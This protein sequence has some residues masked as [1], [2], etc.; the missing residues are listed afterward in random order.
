MTRTRSL[1]VTLLTVPLL[2]LATASPALAV[3]LE[4]KVAVLTS[5]TQTS[6]ASQN[7]FLSARSNQS[8]WA[9]YG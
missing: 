5:W 8:A 1:L 4:Q 9:D 3:T 6:A 2:V 7:A